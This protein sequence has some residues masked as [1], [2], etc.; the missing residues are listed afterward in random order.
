[1]DFLLDAQGEDI[2]AGRHTVDGS[3]E[4]A[5]SPPTCSRR[6]SGSA[7]C[8]RASSRCTGVRADRPGPR[9]FP[10][11]DADRQA[12]PVGGAQIAT[13]QVQEGLITPQTALA[14]L[15]GAGP[16]G[17]PS[18]ARRHRRRGRARRPGDRGQRRRCDRP[19]CA[20]P[21][22]GTASGGDGTPPVLVRADTVDRRCREPCRSPAGVLTGAGGR[23]LTPPSS[24]A[25]SASPVSS[26]AMAP[27]RPHGPDGAHRRPSVRRG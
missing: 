26:A 27:D 6:S 8:S 5:L 23:T 14:R 16:G 24:R 19:D 21:R 15:E 7:R 18:R 17:D 3:S 12:H 9:A 13:A 10:A 20:R 25:S 2:V 22:G 11:A 4:L 1:M